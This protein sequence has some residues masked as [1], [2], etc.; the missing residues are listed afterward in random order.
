MFSTA[1]GRVRSYEI[2]QREGREG[3][4]RTRMGQCGVPPGSVDA[5]RQQLLVDNVRKDE[6]EYLY[7]YCASAR[8]MSEPG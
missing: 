3:S 5:D 1:T 8:Y 6:N 7:V 4:I 2:K